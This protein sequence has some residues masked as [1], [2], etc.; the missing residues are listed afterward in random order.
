ME[1]YFLI[2]NKIRKIIIIITVKLKYPIKK[3]SIFCASKREGGGM[4]LI[5]RNEGN[6]ETLCRM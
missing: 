4:D 6:E 1:I 3:I 2:L 5:A